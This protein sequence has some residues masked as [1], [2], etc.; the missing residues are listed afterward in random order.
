MPATRTSSGWG[1]RNYGGCCEEKDARKCQKPAAMC[2]FPKTCR[3]HFIWTSNELDWIFFRAGFGK[4]IVVTHVILVPFPP[5]SGI[6]I[7]SRLERSRGNFLLLFGHPFLYFHFPLTGS[8]GVNHCQSPLITSWTR[9]DESAP[10]YSCKQLLSM[11][12]TCET[13]TTLSRGKFPSPRFN[14]MFPGAMASLRL[15]VKG[16]TITVLTL[17]WLQIA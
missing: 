5:V 6:R 13:L 15:V 12:W 4:R 11:L 16:H 2:S 14:R 8:L 7:V 17:L 10:I 1:W 3:L 9:A